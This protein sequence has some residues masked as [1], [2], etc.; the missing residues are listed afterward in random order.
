EG[1]VFAADPTLAQRTLLFNIHTGDWEP[2]LL[3]AFGIA[4]QLLPEI[5]PSVG[6]AAVIKSGVH[7]LPVKVCLGDQQAAL[8][9]AG[10]WKP[11]ACV[12]NY[13]TGAFFLANTGSSPCRVPGLLCSAG[14]AAEKA[15]AASYLAEGTVHS[16][17][18][19]FDWLVQIGFGLDKNEIDGLCAQSKNPVL[20]LPALG[21]LGAPHWDYAVG[22]TFAGF[23]PNSTRADLVRGIVQGIAFLISDIA[24][25]LAAGGV[26]L[27]VITASGGLANLDS[28]LQ[29]QADI[30]QRP[31]LRCAETE[32]TALG[33]ACLL[34]GQEGIDTRRWSSL[35]PVRE[36][37][38]AIS[39][40]EAIRLLKRWESMREGSRSL[41]ASLNK[42]S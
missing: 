30:L 15:G 32:T 2:K 8:S 31:V 39:V 3:E 13:G 33:V 16:A 18:S 28:L 27:D 25:P 29:F 5:K 38:P 42:K 9:G 4:R 11:G 36:F 35:S 40:S 41:A 7:S 10:G 6:Q 21:G 34:A 26:Q 24:L 20:A 12:I 22:T 17:S 14:W 23:T 37:R 1:K 19:M